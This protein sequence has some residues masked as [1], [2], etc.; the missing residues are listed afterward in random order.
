MAIRRFEI[1]NDLAVQPTTEDRN[2]LAELGIM[3]A[4]AQDRCYSVLAEGL[5]V[6]ERARQAE[7][8][9]EAAI[10]QEYRASR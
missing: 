3:D 2:R 8:L 9:A 6:A 4:S 5:A 7:K 10:L 1:S